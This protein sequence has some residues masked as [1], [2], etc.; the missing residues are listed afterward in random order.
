[1][2]APFLIA[3]V[4]VATPLFAVEKPDPKLKLEYMK[5]FV[6][7]DGSMDLE[8]S[9]PIPKELVRPFVSRNSDLCYTMRSIFVSK[10]PGS[11]STE[12]V[13]QRTCTPASQF[14]MKHTVLQP[15]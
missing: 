4:L 8:Q 7:N 1:M 3:F 10:E 13:G 2:R 14:E 15:K 12:F 6:V 11:D 9:K 5:P